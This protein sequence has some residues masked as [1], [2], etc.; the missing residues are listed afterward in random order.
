MDSRDKPTRLTA[1]DPNYMR[2]SYAIPHLLLIVYKFFKS[3]IQSIVIL[4][5]L[6]LP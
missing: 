6:W 1:Q 4:R 5:N 2:I 3:A